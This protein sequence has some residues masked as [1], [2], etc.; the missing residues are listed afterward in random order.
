MATVRHVL[1]PAQYRD[2]IR[3]I[4]SL[5]DE[6]FVPPLTDSSRAAVTRT[7]AE[8][9]ASD[10]RGYVKRCLTRPL[11]GA[12]VDDTLVGLLSFEHIADAF[13]VASYTPTNHVEIIAVRPTHR[14][15]G[16]AAAMYRHILHELPTDVARPNVSTKTWDSNVAHIAV[17]DRLGFDLVAREVND[18]GPGIDTVYYAR[19]A[20]VD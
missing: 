19:A 18:R 6:E 2:G 8:G 3:E 9:G 1:E 12:L 13:P 20:G 7:E 11:V 16:L 4:L 10:L 17:L 15:H 5:V 14:G